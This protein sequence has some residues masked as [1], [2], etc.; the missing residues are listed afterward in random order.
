[1]SREEAKELIKIYINF[2]LI[3]RDLK[4]KM[5]KEQISLYQ[6]SWARFWG[7]IRTHF[8]DLYVQ[9]AFKDGEW[10]ENPDQVWEALK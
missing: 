10:P 4:P 3:L 2:M 7:L 8:P 1:M 5:T 6:H 9:K